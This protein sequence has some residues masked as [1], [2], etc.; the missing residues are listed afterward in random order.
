[1]EG[2]L[3]S[4]LCKKRRYHL[5]PLN[6]GIF[7]LH[8]FGVGSST[9]ACGRGAEGIAIRTYV[10]IRTH[11]HSRLLHLHSHICSEDMGR[12]GGLFFFSFL[13]VAMASDA[14]ITFSLS[15]LHGRGGASFFL[16]HC[17]YWP[18]FVCGVKCL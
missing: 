1:M 6:G 16:R 14:P 15:L 10:Y 11:L 17:C 12:E 18:F 8:E 3:F 13:G 9:W 5:G 2:H 7:S 4:D